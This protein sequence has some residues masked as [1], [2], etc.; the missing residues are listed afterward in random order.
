MVTASAVQRVQRVLKYQFTLPNDRNMVGHLVD[1]A[2]KVT[3]HHYGH[4]EPT[5]Q[6]TDE[7]AHLLNARRVQSVCGFVQNEQLGI[8]QQRSR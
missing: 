4:A 5:G 7:L 1:F 8:A 2:Q 6:V 3:G